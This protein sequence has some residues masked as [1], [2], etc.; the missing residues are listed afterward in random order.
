MSSTAMLSVI[1]LSMLYICR[2]LKRIKSGTRHWVSS[3]TGI[4]PRRVR[5]IVAVLPYTSAQ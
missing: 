4:N 1:R 2:E 3:I 5:L